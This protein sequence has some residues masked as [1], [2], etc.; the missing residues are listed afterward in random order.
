MAEQ[1]QGGL[2]E[3]RQGLGADFLRSEAETRARV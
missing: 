2:S 3:S 1:L